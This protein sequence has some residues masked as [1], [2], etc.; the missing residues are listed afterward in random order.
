MTVPFDG[1][2][3]DPTSPEAQQWVRDEL[4]SGGYVTEPSWWQRFLEWLAR[5]FDGPATG[6]LPGWA[7]ALIVG[8]LL[9]AVVLVVL[10]QVRPEAVTLRSRASQQA[11]D[12][13]GLS[14][15]TYRERA[16]AAL[17]GGDWD[18]ALLDSYRA[19][20]TS[21]VERTLLTDLPG[22]TA[23]E[24]ALALAPVFPDHARDVASAADAFDEVRYGHCPAGESRARAAASLEAALLGTRPR[25]DE[26]V[27]T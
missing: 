23:H 1:P 24:V 2:P 11:V 5:Q 14:A 4:A 6:G 9:G 19:I 20:A 25:L 22:R 15:A 12:H 18:G 7:V 21:A 26:A 13:E 8:L 17:A 10:R 3:L 27:P 16:R